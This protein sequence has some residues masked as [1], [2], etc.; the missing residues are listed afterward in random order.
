M[1]RYTVRP[2]QASHNEEL[3]REVLAELR[4]VQPPGLRYAAFRLD[5]GVSFVHLI[6]RDSEHGPGPPPQLPALK[7]FHAGIRERCDEGPVRT[8]L[9]EI[10][11]YRLLCDG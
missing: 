6:S 11:S 10:G 9:D 4:R 3:I 1:V 8:G 7:A 5:D 2:D